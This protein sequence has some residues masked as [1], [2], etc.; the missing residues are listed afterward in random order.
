M[1]KMIHSCPSQGY[2]RKLKCKQPY[3]GFELGAQI[4]FPTHEE[5]FAKRD[6]ITAY[7]RFYL[8][9]ED[10]LGVSMLNGQHR[11]K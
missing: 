7:T 2:Q 1:R 6:D 4:L 11:S 8:S 5:R 10:T 9:R 3:P